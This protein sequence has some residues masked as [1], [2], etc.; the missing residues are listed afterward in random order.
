MQSEINDLK[1]QLTQY[2]ID[3]GLIQRIQCSK[4]DRKAYKKLL[5]S[6]GKLPD[7]V[8]QSDEDPEM[9]YIIYKADLSKDEWNEYLSY[10]KIQ[11]LKII[12]DCAVFFVILTVIAMVFA[13][14]SAIRK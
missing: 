5:K 13:F 6:G 1:E 11:L 8:F 7:G 4:E 12:K 14:I 10:R 9:F 2:R 3:S